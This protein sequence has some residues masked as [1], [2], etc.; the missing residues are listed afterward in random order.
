MTTEARAALDATVPLVT[1][2]KRTVQI[3]LSGTDCFALLQIPYP[4]SEG[5]WNELVAYLT[6]TKMALTH[7]AEEAK[8]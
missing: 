1:R 5:N 6:V 7:H 4:L 8:P 2:T 3:P